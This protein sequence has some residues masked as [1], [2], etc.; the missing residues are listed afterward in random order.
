MAT[1]KICGTCKWH[2]YDKSH[3]DWMCVNCKS[4]YHTDFTGYEDGCDEWEGRQ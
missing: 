2:R 4:D 1:E 3:S